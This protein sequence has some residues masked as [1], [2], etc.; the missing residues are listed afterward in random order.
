M[1]VKITKP[2][3]NCRLGSAMVAGAAANTDIAIAGINV[4]DELLAVW[5]LATSTALPTDRTATSAILTAG[6]IQCTD[7]TDSDVLLVLWVSTT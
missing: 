4:A 3:K 7:A 2:Y 5:E 6:N 1:S